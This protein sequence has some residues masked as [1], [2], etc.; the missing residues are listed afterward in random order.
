[1]NSRTICN[2]LT[3]L[4]MSSI[5]HAQLNSESIP[6]YSWS[7]AC[8]SPSKRNHGCETS[9]QDSLNNCFIEMYTNLHDNLY[10]CT[11]YCLLN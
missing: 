4:L 1:M 9:Q 6:V 3:D 11:I 7:D 5:K 2:K 10:K 8:I